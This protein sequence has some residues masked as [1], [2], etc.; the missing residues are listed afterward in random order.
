M[1]KTIQAE[2]P[3]QIEQ[4]RK[5][6]REYE[7]WIGL[8]LCFQD[9]DAEVA[10]LP[11]KYAAPDGRLFLA[12]SDEKLAGCVALRKLEEGVCEMKRLFV[13][14]D[15]RGLRIGIKLIEKLIDEARL[16]GYK[17]LRLD[18]YPPKMGKAVGIYESYG[19]REIPAYYHNPYGDSLFMELDLTV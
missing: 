2:T 3:E 11:G 4:A 17:T 5:I 7:V 16:I 1:I 18:T 10:N 6:F 9:F 19:F 8:S 15:F 14:E 13:K 12:F